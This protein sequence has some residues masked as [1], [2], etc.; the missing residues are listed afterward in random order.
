MRLK[1]C[2]AAA[3]GL[4][5][6]V[7]LWGCAAK[8]RPAGQEAETQ[9]IAETDLTEGETAGEDTSELLTETFTEEMEFRSV[10]EILD[11]DTIAWADS[12]DAGEAE[13][14]VYTNLGE[15]K[16]EYEVT[17]STLIKEFYVALMGL[18]VAGLADTYAQDAGDTYDFY[19]K[20]G[21]VVHFAF[22]MGSL[23]Q[24]DRMY[25]TDLADRLWE[26]TGNLIPEEDL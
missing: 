7:L 13:R 19:M 14:L 3:A 22:C 16:T 10:R 18:T 1:K 11:E 15:T 4:L 8:P 25:E 17:D 5:M 20:D 26:L 24:G 9:V 12:F 2:A 21:K 6:A 23:L